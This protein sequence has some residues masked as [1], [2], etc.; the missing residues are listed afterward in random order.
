MNSER[1]VLRKDYRELI[2]N[3]LTLGSSVPYEVFRAA[4]FTATQAAEA[5][6]EYNLS[7]EKLAESAEN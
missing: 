1:I 4:S 2:R 3:T 5:H 6:D 7:L